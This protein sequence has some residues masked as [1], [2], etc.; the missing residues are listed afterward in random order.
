LDRVRESPDRIVVSAD[1]AE[2][3]GRGVALVLATR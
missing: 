1:V 2:F 3:I